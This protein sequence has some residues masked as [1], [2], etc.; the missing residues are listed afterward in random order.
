MEIL[1]LIFIHDEYP[2]KAIEL[3]KGYKPK[4]FKI[5]LR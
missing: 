5:L 3:T 1:W 2:V 4:S